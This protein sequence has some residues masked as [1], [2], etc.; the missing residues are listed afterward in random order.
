MLQKSAYKRV[1][2]NHGLAKYDQ[3][4]RGLQ[5]VDR[6]I[7]VSSMNNITGV[8]SNVTEIFY[9]CVTRCIPANT[10]TIR[11]DDKPF[12]NNDIRLTMR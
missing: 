5:S 12:M 10:V 6:G 3:L 4:I 8:F 11:P 7:N 2:R 9:S 1:I